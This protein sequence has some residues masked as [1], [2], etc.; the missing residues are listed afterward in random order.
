M[1][2]YL[3]SI[4]KTSR[5]RLEDV[6]KTYDQCKCIGLD[7]EVLKT[8]SADEDERH[9]QDVFKMHLSRQMFAGSILLRDYD[10]ET[11]NNEIMGVAAIAEKQ[12]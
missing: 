1:I 2:I 7:Q 12:Q 5:K 4:L 6:L 8:S 10:I 11:N 3:E 9:L